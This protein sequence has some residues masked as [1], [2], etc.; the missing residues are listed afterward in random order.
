MG[1]N[2][3]KDV[4]KL[5]Q[6]GFAVNPAHKAAL[7][8]RLLDGSMTL[9]IDDLENVTG[10]VTMDKPKFEDWPDEPNQE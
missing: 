1:K 2:T 6:C 7:K 4:E 8:S 10:G 5:L 9:S 3:E